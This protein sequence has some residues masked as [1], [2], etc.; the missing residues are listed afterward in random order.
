[1]NDINEICKEISLLDYASQH[2]TFKRNGFSNNWY[3]RCPN[4]TDLTPSLCINNEQN[5]FHCFSCEVGGNLLTWMLKIEHMNYSDAVKRIAE[6][7]GKEII[8]NESSKSMKYFRS[9]KPTCKNQNPNERQIIDPIYYERCL[10][11]LP[12]EWIKEGIEP[13]VMNEYGIRIDGQSNRIC[14]PILDVNGKLISMKG[15]TR[16]P[17]YKELGIPKYQFYSKIGNLDFFVGW[18]QAWPYIQES[19]RAY[20]FE[21]IKSVMHVRP[22]GY[23]NCISSETSHLSDEQIKLLIKSRIK[24]V[25]ICYDSDV[26]IDK[27]R[28]NVK[29]LRKFCDIYYTGNKLLGEKESPCDRGREVFEKLI[30]EVKKI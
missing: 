6:L 26:N 21:G 5:Y 3:C 12:E 25:V 15:R 14:Y 30:K 2:F 10:R 24:E 29:L 19:G 18:Q 27:V 17:S 9:I 11:E 4:H 1:M 28:D 22:W 20:I 7:S 16:I 8:S 13:S 23:R